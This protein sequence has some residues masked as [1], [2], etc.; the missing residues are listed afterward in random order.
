MEQKKAT[1][2]S[3]Y[4]QKKKLREEK[5]ARQDVRR[6]RIK[7]GKK[8]FY[9]VLVILAVVTVGYGGVSLLQQAEKTRPGTTFAIQGQTHIDVGA[10][11]PAYN[12]NPPTS[13]WH[14]IQPA[15]WG[16]Y[17][18]ELP[19]EQLIHNLEHGGIW[20]SYKN[21]DQQTKDALEKI[22]GRES[23]VVVG[24]RSK[25]SAP[26]VLA[27]WGR[28]LELQSFDEKI[29]RDFIKANRNRSPEPYAQ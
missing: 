6:A 2:S 15:P 9:A 19:D 20:I 16:P 8:L 26:I 14:Y 18:N 4:E 5:K 1:Q 13:G 25:N 28:L 29:V 24:P 12:S 23:K 10:E 22:A 17:Q 3:E 27:S 7:K 21:V 11:H